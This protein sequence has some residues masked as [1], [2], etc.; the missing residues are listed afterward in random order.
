MGDFPSYHLLPLIIFPAKVLER[1]RRVMETDKERMAGEK[2]KKKAELI[3]IFINLWKAQTV[4]KI[5]A[6]FQVKTLA[7]WYIQYKGRIQ[8]LAKQ[9]QYVI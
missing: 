5:V 9:Y 7:W 2:K 3:A 8:W 6:F 4:L 1:G